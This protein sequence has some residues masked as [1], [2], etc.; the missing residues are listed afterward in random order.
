[1]TTAQEPIQSSPWIS[2]WLRP[3][4][5][6]EHIVATQRRQ[7]VLLLASLGAMSGLA[8]WL[9]SLGRPNQLLDWRVLLG[10]AVVGAIVGIVG[11]YANALV[12]KGTGRL[13][14]GRAAILEF[15]AL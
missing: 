15:R 10:L 14:G 2:V 3:R 13:M 11:M 12:L 7:N 4:G 9:V 1:M 8:T 5:T 6:I